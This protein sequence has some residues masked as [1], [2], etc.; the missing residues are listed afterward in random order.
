[1]SG[2]V[3]LVVTGGSLTRMTEKVSSQSRGRGTLTK[4]EYLNHRLNANY[5]GLGA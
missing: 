1:L 3:R 5:V 2:Y 4:N